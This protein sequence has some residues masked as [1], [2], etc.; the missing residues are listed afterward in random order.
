MGWTFGIDLASMAVV[1]AADRNETSAVGRVARV[2]DAFL[3]SGDETMSLSELA[4]RTALPKSTAHRLSHQLL[5]HGLLERDGTRLRLGLKLFELGA[6]APQQRALRDAARAT[7]TDLRE[8]TRHTVNLAI[9]DGNEVVY[10]E[11]LHGPDAPVVPTRVGGRWPVH[12]TGVGKAILAFSPDPVVEEILSVPLVRVSERTVVA[13]GLL[14]QELRRIR[15]LGVARD[16]EES[17]PGLVCAASP[18][19][20]PDGRVA[21]ALSVSGWSNRMNVDRVAPA[22]RTAALTVSRALAMRVG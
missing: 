3:Y 21:G 2:L 19:L 14:R 13:S 1:R 7:M 4:R 8:A 10:L 9:L 16:N 5:E 12:A 22:V 18:V 15:E 11:I 6:L 20:W 17:R